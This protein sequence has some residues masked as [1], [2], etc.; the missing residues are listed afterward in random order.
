MPASDLTPDQ[1]TDAIAEEVSARVMASHANASPG[2][3]RMLV[4]LYTAQATG[5]APAPGRISDRW[6]GMYL[7]MAPQRVSE[8]RSRALAKAW[9]AM[10]TQDDKTQDAR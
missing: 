7:A 5:S 3:R 1:I 2:F 4:R 9:K 6:L 10:K 8:T